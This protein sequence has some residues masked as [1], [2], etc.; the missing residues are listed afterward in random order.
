MVTPDSTLVLPLQQQWRASDLKLF[1][2]LLTVHFGT[3]PKEHLKG[4]YF[5]CDEEVQASVGKWFL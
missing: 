4:I 1:H 2:A 3:A 5:M